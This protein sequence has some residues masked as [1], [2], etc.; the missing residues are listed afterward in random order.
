MHADCVFERFYN[1]FFFLQADVPKLQGE[2][3]R[4]Q[5]Q[6]QVHPAHGHCARGRASLQIC[7]QQMVSFGPRGSR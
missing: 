7:G 6:N 1:F 3:D 4:T 2:G 5:P